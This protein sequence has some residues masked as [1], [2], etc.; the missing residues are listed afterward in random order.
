MGNA[1][2][3]SSKSYETFNEKHRNFKI[4]FAIRQPPIYETLST[5]SDRYKITLTRHWILYDISWN[6]KTDL[7]I[8]VTYKL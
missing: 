7:D 6:L 4:I 8:L 1:K 2:Y 5:Y 3:F